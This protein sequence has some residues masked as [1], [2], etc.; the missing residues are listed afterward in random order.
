MSQAAVSVAGGQWAK[1]IIGVVANRCKGDG[2]NE[3]SACEM[4]CS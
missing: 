1:E 2:R 3:G 4:G